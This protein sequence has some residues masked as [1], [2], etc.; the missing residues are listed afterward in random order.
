MGKPL[1]IA[2]AFVVLLVAGA[3]AWR[4][5]HI[6][7]LARVGAGYVAQQTCNCLFIS[8]RAADSCHKDLERM[9]QWFITV[10]VGDAQVST[11]AFG[12]ARATSRYQ[13]GFGC[14][15]AE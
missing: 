11:H 9:A 10:K 12:V 7:D 5:M 6:S 4:L 15:L 13:A 2:I 3:A 1:K 8:R 14:S